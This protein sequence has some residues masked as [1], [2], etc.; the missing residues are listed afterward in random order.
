MPWSLNGKEKISQYM[1]FL[2]TC[3]RV[4]KYNS[5]NYTF[6]IMIF[7]VIYLFLDIGYVLINS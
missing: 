3:K 2:M 6:V 7:L 5:L 4:V 1:Y